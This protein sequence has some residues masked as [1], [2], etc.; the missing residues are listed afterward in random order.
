MQ[1]ERL[2][3]M[4]QVTATVSHELRNPLGTLSS[5]L[6]VLRRVLRDADPAVR[7]ELERMQRNIRRCV[8]I[9]EDLL[10]FSREKAVDMRPVAMDRWLAA[11]LADITLPEYVALKLD[12]RS[13]ASVLIDS[14]QFR[15]VIVNLIQNAH[16]A[17]SLRE[18]GG[19]SGGTV[20]VRTAAAGRTFELRVED[21]GCGIRD[22]ISDK[23][24][25]PLFSTKAFGVGLGLPLVKRIVERH[26][27]E[28]TI[29][30]SWGNGTVATVRL[31]IA[32]QMALPVA[33]A[34]G[35]D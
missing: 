14:A 13:D 4:G 15:Q 1:S 7:E 33:R 32:Q 3:T 31:P 27:G 34:I 23:I 17:I 22:E 25:K 11:Q 12:L 28:I 8:R 30:S 18:P 2:A 20:T 10:D 19:Q 35:L 26:H 21:D 5:S 16:Q 29:E 9:I 24:F 6:G